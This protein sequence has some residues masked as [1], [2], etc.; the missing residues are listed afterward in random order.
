[1]RAQSILLALLVAAAST[2]AR[3]ALG[4]EVTQGEM[5]LL[6]VTLNNT[7]DV[8]LKDVQPLWDES[9]EWVEPIGIAD[10]VAVAKGGSARL[11]IRLRVARN[12]PIGEDMTLRLG[13]VDDAGSRWFRDTTITVLP[14]PVPT[15]TRAFPNYP[16]PFN[17]ET[18]IPYEL[19]E[20]SDVSL[21]IY[22][23]G[24]QTVRKLDLG[25]Q[26]AGWYTSR[27][28]AAY[29]DGRNDLGEQVGSGL[30][31]YRLRAGKYS[32]MRKLVVAR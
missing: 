29:W 9:P 22:D 16:N 14:R 11:P 30:Y 23:L 13:L 21:W 27:S 3:S 4:V 20:A 10:P 25:Y 17:P 32:A 2:A 19:H 6:N 26:E 24:G 12:G 1:M 18:W 5:L 28:Q 8:P 15:Q 7:G 31:V